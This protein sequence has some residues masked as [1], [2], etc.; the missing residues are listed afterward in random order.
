MWPAPCIR[1]RLLIC[2]GCLF[3]PRTTAS[4]NLLIS[5]LQSGD[6][7]WIHNICTQCS[8]ANYVSYLASTGV[9]PIAI[10]AFPKSP[11]T[12]RPNF[13]G[14]YHRPWRQSGSPIDGHGNRQQ[15]HR[16]KSSTGIFFNGIIGHVRD[17]W[18][19]YIDSWT[20]SSCLA[21]Y[22]RRFFNIEEVH[23][24]TRA[25]VTFRISRVFSPTHSCQV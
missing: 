10:A 16:K 12:S 14:G 25:M 3:S 4:G 23:E 17:C 18:E 2:C 24:Q 9:L 22:W 20:E 6:R 8:N 7:I 13:Q 19:G 15:G 5:W 11:G 1:C 21:N